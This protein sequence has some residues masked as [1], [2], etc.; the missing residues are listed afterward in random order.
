MAQ[1]NLLELS[2]LLSEEEQQQTIAEFVAETNRTLA[3]GIKIKDMAI[4]TKLLLVCNKEYLFCSLVNINIEKFAINMR[5]NGYN[6]NMEENTI[7]QYI[8]ITKSYT[9]NDNV[10]AYILSDYTFSL[11]EK[12]IIKFFDLKNSLQKECSN[13]FNNSLSKEVFYPIFHVPTRK[14]F[15]TCNLSDLIYKHLTNNT[16]AELIDKLDRELKS[17][18]TMRS[19]SLKID[20]SYIGKYLILEDG[21]LMPHFFDKKQDRIIA[22]YFKYNYC[23]TFSQKIDYQPYN[24]KSKCVVLEK[25]DNTKKYIDNLLFL[26]KEFELIQLDIEKLPLHEKSI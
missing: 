2:K 21:I 13:I 5:V 23:L 14:E 9:V 1:I 4:N 16:I 20:K 22:T 3:L 7:C 15:L 26:C 17:Q 12:R 6:I 18:K 11:L 8:N 25:N 10:K 24:R 19:L